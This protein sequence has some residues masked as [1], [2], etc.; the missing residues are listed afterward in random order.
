MENRSS[1]P[2]WFS[3][4]N[5]PV[6]PFAENLSLLRLFPKAVPLYDTM[7]IEQGSMSIWSVLNVFTKLRARSHLEKTAIC[8]QCLCMCRAASWTEK[9]LQMEN[10]GWILMAPSE[11]VQ[12]PSFHAQTSTETGDAVKCKKMLQT[13]VEGCMGKRVVKSE[14]GRARREWRE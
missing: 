13:P 5:L 9:W 3:A 8:D 12:D 2:T 11:E 6:P 14:A 7:W 1:V 10:V 4:S